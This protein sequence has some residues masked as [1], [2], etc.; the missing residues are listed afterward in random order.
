[1]LRVHGRTVVYPQAA[2]PTGP[3]EGRGPRG[4]KSGMMQPLVVPEAGWYNYEFFKNILPPTRK[5]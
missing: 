5:S 1:M 2:G 3:P 4:A